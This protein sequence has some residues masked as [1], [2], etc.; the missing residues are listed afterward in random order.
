MRVTHAAKTFLCLMHRGSRSSERWT[1]PKRIFK[2]TLRPVRAT[3]EVARVVIA[4]GPKVPTST[5]NLPVISPEKPLVAWTQ[6]TA[7]PVSPWL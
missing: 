3:S 4:V 1:A 5:T 7:L 6:S 2:L